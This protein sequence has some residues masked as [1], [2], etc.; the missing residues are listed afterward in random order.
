MRPGRRQRFIYWRVASADVAAALRAARAVQAQLRL[1]HPTL[2]T[3]LYLRTEAPA[4][5]A[6]LME[7][8]ALDSQAAR[9]G[10][11]AAMQ[12]RIEAASAEALRPWLRGARHVEVFDACDD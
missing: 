9:N 6:T 1:S 10:I 12:Q 8:Y 5:E 3:G 2:R 11:D 7:V 4:G